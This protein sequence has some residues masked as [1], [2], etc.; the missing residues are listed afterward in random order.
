MEREQHGI[1][2]EEE[3]SASYTARKKATQV[4]RLFIARSRR[5]VQGAYAGKMEQSSM[6]VGAGLTGR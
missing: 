1:D 3:S 2:G 6:A 4:R 5:K